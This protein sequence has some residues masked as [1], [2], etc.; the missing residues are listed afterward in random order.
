MPPLRRQYL[1]HVAARRDVIRA[2]R[3]RDLGVTY[4]P[5]VIVAYNGIAGRAYWHTAIPRR[6]LPL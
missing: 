5:A 3:A 2:A 1:Q 4:V 6:M